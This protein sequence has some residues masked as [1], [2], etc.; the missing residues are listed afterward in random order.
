MKNTQR[1][2]LYIDDETREHLEILA[3]K[4]QRSKNN[5]I[6]FLVN[7]EFE[8]NIDIDTI[9]NNLNK[10][11]ANDIKIDRAVINEAVYSE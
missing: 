9:S 1:M 11:K 3:K 4:Y 8:N 5:L 10:I 2:S 7:K 6:T